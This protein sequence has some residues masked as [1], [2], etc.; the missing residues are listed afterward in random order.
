MKKAMNA[1]FPHYPRGTRVARCHLFIVGGV[2]RSHTPTLNMKGRD[3]EEE[4]GTKRAPAKKRTKRPRQNATKRQKN[5]S[6][7]KD[8]LTLDLRIQEM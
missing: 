6:E 2:A 1:G 7:G 4:N 3:N 8:F 5:K